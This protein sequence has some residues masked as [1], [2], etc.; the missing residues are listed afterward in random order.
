MCVKAIAG[1][2]WLWQMVKAMWEG[3]AMGIPGLWRASLA[4]K[5]AGWAEV[6]LSAR[7][8]LAPSRPPAVACAPTAPCTAWGDIG[9]K[10]QHKCPL[11]TSLP[12]CVLQLSK[13]Y[14]CLLP[15]SASELLLVCRVW[16][17]WEEHCRAAT[18]HRQD[19]QKANCRLGKG[20]Q[21][22]FAWIKKG[23][24]RK[25]TPSFRKAHDSLKPLAC[26]DQAVLY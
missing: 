22:V 12:V 25:K 4:A 8:L 20:T 26:A 11:P 16:D 21:A 9:G 13:S 10:W 23:E 7:S 17:I 5:W 1:C 6:A 14:L 2:W 24:T 19:F 15:A 3:A 18:V